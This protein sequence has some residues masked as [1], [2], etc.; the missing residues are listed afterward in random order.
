MPLK[1]TSVHDD[2][3]KFKDYWKRCRVTY[4]GE[5]AVHDEGVTLLPKIEGQSDAQYESYKQRAR[6]MNAVRRTVDGLTGLVFRKEPNIE[7]DGVD[8]FLDDVSL[9]KQPM[10][11]YCQSLTT[12]IL[13]V[14][15]GGTL[16]DYPEEVKGI[17][18][19]QAEKM[20]MRP[21]FKFYTAESVK[22][23]RY[24]TKNNVVTLVEVLLEE[25]YQDEQGISRKQYRNLYLKDNVYVQLLTKETAT[26]MPQVQEIIPTM[27]NKTIN[28]IPFVFHRG[29]SG[30]Q[31]DVPVLTDLVDTNLHHYEQ[32]ADHAHGLRYVALPTPYVTG[33]D[34]PPT[35]GQDG[36]GNDIKAK[37]S[38]G[39]YEFLFAPDPSSKVGYLEFSGAGLQAIR[40]QLNRLEST[41]AQQGAKILQP[42][43]SGGFETATSAVIGA[44]G[45]TSLLAR[46]AN[47]I[48]LEVSTAFQF[49]AMWMGKTNTDNYKVDLSTDFLPV[50][51]TAQDL[52]A[53][54]QSWIAG[55]ISHETYFNN[56]KKGEVYEGEDS[57]EDEVERISKQTPPPSAELNEEDDTGDE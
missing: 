13:I 50:P 36:E 6:F 1:T 51:M 44:K 21:M 53:L 35:T 45:E 32:E 17:S 56:L 33:A 24:E 15:A 10:T 14:T 47:T 23:W 42:E 25:E 3:T 38:I 43:T 46:V 7:G 55:G 5:K 48:S 27:N 20:N 57:F 12:E 16:V 2:Y 30:L 39:P 22:N 52:T 40:E 4:A 28:F 54:T 26:D 9:L 37:M 18:K 31:Y 41:M 19:A 8:N 34:G 49:A 11:D 29:K